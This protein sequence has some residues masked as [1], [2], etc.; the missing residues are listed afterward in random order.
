MVWCWRPSSSRERATLPNQLFSRIRMLCHQWAP[1]DVAQSCGADLAIVLSLSCRW[2]KDGES[3]VCLFAPNK[4]SQVLSCPDLQS[5]DAKPTQRGAAQHSSRHRKTPCTCPP[6][7]PQNTNGLAR[8]SRY[9][10]PQWLQL[11]LTYGSQP[12]AIHQHCHRSAGSWPQ[13]IGFKKDSCSDLCPILLLR[14]LY[15][16]RCILRCVCAP[17]L[18]LCYLSHTLAHPA[19]AFEWAELF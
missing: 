7:G 5:R 11:W 18:L 12:K 1:R 9:V 8:V 10:T 14:H 17:R 19:K 13:C 16:R 4:E 15:N 2:P 6:A 3:G